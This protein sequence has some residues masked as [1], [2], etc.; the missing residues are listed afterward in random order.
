MRPIS[1]PKTDEGSQL[2]C[3][4]IVHRHP[5]Q[6][7]D[8]QRQRR[9]GCGETG[10]NAAISLS[11]AAVEG[12]PITATV[13][14]PDAPTSGIT[15]TWTVN[16]ATVKTGVDA[17]GSSYTPI[18]GNEGGVLAV[19]VSFTDTHGNVETGNVSA[20]TVAEKPGENAAISLSGAAV[21][22]APITATVT[23]PDAPTSG[24]TYTWTV[25]GATVKT[26][27]DAAGSSYTP[28]EGNEGGVLAVAVSFTDTHGN[29]ETGNVSAGTVAEKPGENAAIS[30]SGA[31]VEGAPITATVTEPD[32]P[33]S[34]ITYT[35]TVNGATVKTGVDAAGSSYTP[36]EGNEGGVLAVAV[37]FTDTHGNVETGNVSAGTVAEKPGEN[38]AISLSGAAVEGAPITATVTEPDAPTSG[39]TYTWTVNGAT[40]KTGV[41]AA[42]SSYT[43]IEGNEG[44]VLAVAVSFTD[45]HGNV[46]TGNVSAGT[47]AEK[48]GE[49]A[50][51][52]LSGAA[53][54]GAPITA[55]VTE[56]DAPTS[57]ITYTWTVNGATVKTG[58]DAAG[59]SYTPIEGNEGGVLAVAVSFTDTHGNV[60]TGNVSAGTVAEKPGE[61][62]AISLS[63]AAVEGAPITATVTEP[64]APTSGI[65]YT[66]TVN[67]AT[68]KTG[69]DAAGSSYTPIEGNEGG[70][71]AVAV[72]F[73]DTH[74]NVE[75][76]NV[77]A[78][79]V[80]EKP[81]EN[82]AIS[83]SG[84]AV[85]G[86]PITATVTEPDAPTSGITYTWT[87][88]GATV[89]TGVDAAGSSYT[90]IEGNEGGVLAVAVSFT[91][92]HGNV[93]T[94]NV[95]AGTVAEKPGENAAISLSGAAVE[96]APITATVTEPDAPTSGITYTWTVNGATVKT[97]VDAAGSS[98]TP[99]EG[100]EGGVLAVAVSFTDTHGNVETGNV[101][102]GT[103]AE[104]PGENAAIS[105]SGAA[106]EGAPITATVTEPDAP[107]SG[108]TYTWTVNGATVKT[109]V[110]AAGSS[111]TPIEG[112]EGGVLAVAVSFTDTHG[113]VETG[114]VSAGTV[115][116]KPGENAAISLSGAAVEGAPITATVT[117][118]DAPTSGITY[119]WTVN[120]A[121]VKTGVDAAGSSYTPIEG[122]EGGVL[123]VAVSFTDTHGNVETGNVSAGTVAEK[124][125]ENAAISLSGAAVE[126]APITATVTEPD[127]PTSG[128][129][130]TWT[131]NGATVKTGVDAAGSSYTPIEGNEGGVLAVAVSF[132][133]TH[134]NVETGNVSAGTV[135][136]KP[137][138]NAAISLSGAAVEG[139]PITATVTEPDAPTSGITYTWTVNG[140]TVKTG[141][142]AAG[143]SYTPIEG[144]EGGVLAVAVSFTD[145]HGNVETGNVS[146]GTVAEK[147]GENAAISLSGAAVEGA[148]IT[149]T[150]TEPDAPTSGITY[151][152]DGQWTAT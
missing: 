131:V 34:G 70:V 22:G 37:S 63:G 115:A 23:E 71:L 73:T 82:A 1:R 75:T 149:A 101:S 57:G 79:T 27:V 145:T 30:L 136:E 67:G 3:Q 76:G 20:G 112:N 14:E 80:A 9:H 74:G 86:A 65:T 143:S 24:I 151:T 48:P 96:G 152:L 5:R 93:E 29:V 111:Y 21:E 150:V 15:Y 77:S 8:R 130:Y 35:W 103:V 140:A 58:V 99:I 125:G 132:T 52:S 134:G 108:I 10:E 36:I 91:D 7:R 39:I 89:K 68:V 121:T 92:T 110:D 138:E 61:N 18:E 49:N 128:I 135:A 113:N 38:A 46:E 25:N 81:G 64:D 105:L 104:K 117:E 2:R 78:G 40:V 32:A 66:W 109:G 123:A 4:C 122:N 12:A 106:V 60:E 94:G 72:S 139:A 83:L 120:G 44:G 137:G 90:P 124:P 114:N 31:A 129:T 6:R 56:P 141:V 62:A 146:A 127:A 95:S 102:A 11:G 28:I 55:T 97:G 59:S 133:D 84:A 116:E 148:P 19:A 47:V 144:N 54:E 42:G 100:N 147:P 53:V 119:T 142:D 45:T 13:T 50:A 33:T 85:E 26:G 69:V 107:T 98:Y 126:G 51:I 87:V 118:P 16:G 88:N 43:P 41:D 17:A